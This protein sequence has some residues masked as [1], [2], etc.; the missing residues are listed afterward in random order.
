MWA[1]RSGIAALLTY[2]LSV[3]LTSLLVSAFLSS[4][5]IDDAHIKKESM[6]QLSFK[7]LST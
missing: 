5:L 4:L 7:T 6:L 3:N 1:G 2:I